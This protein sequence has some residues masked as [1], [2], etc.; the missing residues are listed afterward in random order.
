[1]CRGEFDRLEGSGAPLTLEDQALVPEALRVAHR[2]LGNAGCLPPDLI[3][4][5]EITELEGLLQQV[6]GDGERDSMQRRVDLLKTRLSAEGRE[7]NLLVQD[8]IY[9]QKILQRMAR[10]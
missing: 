2:I 8:G 1:M 10:G 9:R 3:L 7:L 5:R 4:R 6:E